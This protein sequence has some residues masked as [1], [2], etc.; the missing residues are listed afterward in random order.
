MTQ[1]LPRSFA[2]WMSS[3]YLCQKSDDF[4]ILESL[5]IMDGPSLRKDVFKPLSLAGVSILF[6]FR[7]IASR[8]FELD[9]DKGCFLLLKPCP[10]AVGVSCIQIDDERMNGKVWEL[11]SE[12]A[13]RWRELQQSNIQHG[14]RR[15]LLC[16]IVVRK[17]GKQSPR[18]R[19]A[20]F[21]HLLKYRS[22]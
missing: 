14:Q 6:K 21:A 11:L 4:P 22:L 7:D 20:A 16:S 19:L 1:G 8:E 2:L 12:G 3:L 17:I 5:T 9:I 13:P 15:Y 10:I 18:G